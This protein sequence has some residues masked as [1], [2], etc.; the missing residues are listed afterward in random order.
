MD[1]IQ[2]GTLSI[3]MA[4][5]AMRAM[6][7]GASLLTGARP[8]GAGKTTLMAAIL[9]FLPPDVPLVTVDG[10]HVIR[11]GQKRPAAEPACYLA[12]EIG[13]GNWYG[14]IWG[15]HVADFFSLIDGNRRVA[16]CLRADTLDEVIDTS[17]SLVHGADGNR[18][19]VLDGHGATGRLPRLVEAEEKAA[20]R[21][22]LD[23]DPIRP[24]KPR[25]GPGGRFAPPARP[26]G[27]EVHTALP[28]LRAVVDEK[29]DLV[30]ADSAV[31]DPHRNSCI[32]GPNFGVEDTRQYFGNAG[33]G[34]E[35][36]V[37]AHAASGVDLAA[38]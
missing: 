6:H 8:G 1:L 28:R 13:S 14:Y 22:E 25:D 34:A 11:E 37:D 2:A 29:E 27:R 3:E 15:R 18:G 12:H 4:A 7:A 19:Q 33:H 10:P 24:A 16:S 17:R 21:S 30:T 5:Y 32:G 20:V 26:L 23:V 36:Q 9:N 31:R 38:R 35:R